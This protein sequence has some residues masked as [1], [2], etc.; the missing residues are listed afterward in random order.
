MFAGRGL[1]PLLIV[2]ATIAAMAGAPATVRAGQGLLVPAYFYPGTGGPGGV[3]DG[4]AAMTAAA[5][6]VP[7]TAIFN[8]DS[9]PGPGEDP[10]YAAAMTSLEHAGGKV[11]A[12]I[13]TDYGNTPVSTVESEVQTYLGQYGGLINGFFLDGMSN[14]PG[15]VSYYN[16]IYTFIKGLSSSNQ[17]IGN[18]GTATD[19]A[20]LT[21]PTADTFVTFEND[22]A[23]YP[24]AT[25]PSWVDDYPASDFANVIYDQTS[26]SGMLADLALAAQRNVG[27]VYVTDEPINPPSGYLYDQLPSYWDQEVAALA[28][29]PEPGPLVHAAICGALGLAYVGGRKLRGWTLARR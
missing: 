23:G 7:V 11:V 24:G 4:W 3:G 18:P 17:V 22:A 1:L 21:T 2:V 14:L 25:P 6:Q 12:Y 10:T 9:G 15:E 26:V 8:P 20:Y 16:Q 29:V 27:S 13:Y 5:S 28:A 19:Q